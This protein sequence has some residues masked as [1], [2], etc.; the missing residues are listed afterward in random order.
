MCIRDRSNGPDSESNTITF[1]L[2]DGESQTFS[3]Q[4]TDNCTSLSMIGETQVNIQSTLP[5]N[6]DT[7]SNPPICVG[8]EGLV[9]VNP[10]GESD[11]TVVWNNVQPTDIVNG[12]E[13]TVFPQSYSNTYSGVIIDN[14]NLQETAFQIPLDIFQYSGPSFV[15]E[16]GEGC[17]GELLELNVNDLFTDVPQSFQDF[18]FD[19]STG[20][21]STETFIYVQDEPE[22]YSV[23][24]TDLCGNTNTEI[25]TVSVSYTH[26]KLPTIYSV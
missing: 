7:Q 4:I 23:S 5:P 20:E 6:I 10:D 9:S 13:M 19:W 8:F 21:T 16:D 24:I 25:F 2:D 17:E 14:C 22:E 11:Y 15:V 1:D 26:L 18:S 12:N 3:L